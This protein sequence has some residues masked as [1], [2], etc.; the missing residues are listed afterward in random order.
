MIP[1]RPRTR[2]ASRSRLGAPHLAALVALLVFGAFVYLG[3]T[4]LARASSVRPPA[5]ALAPV[6]TTPVQV[7]VA[8]AD[9]PGGLTPGTCIEYRAAKAG[10]KTVFV[11]PG[12]GGLDPGA[13]GTDSSGKQVAEKT[14]TLAV[15]LDLAHRLLADGYNVVMAR[16]QDVNVA[17]MTAA[18]QL[19]GSMTAS[20]VR[21]DTL[22]RVGCANG[23]QADALVSIHFDAFDDPSV[24]GVETLYDDARPFAAASAALAADVHAGVLARF[25]AGGWAV[26]DRGVWKDSDADSNALTNEGTAYGHLLEL[27]PPQAGWVDRPSLMPGALIEPLFVTRPSEADLG[28]SRAGQDAIATGIEDGLKKFFSATP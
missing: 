22:A 3:A 18:D 11:D 15:G 28:S 9:A 4:R 16:T 14:L 6:P 1:Q 26:P 23:A 7:N 24:G 13:V 12:H 20:A 27:G 5:P 17:R 10:R 19:S 25:Q 2:R 8:A 21:R